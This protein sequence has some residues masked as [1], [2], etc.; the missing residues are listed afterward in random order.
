MY[1]NGF[2][3]V[4]LFQVNN[5]DLTNFTHSEAVSALCASMD[6]VKLTIQHDPLPEGWLVSLYFFKS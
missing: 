4:S 1:I 6:E 2:Y 3:L 5:I